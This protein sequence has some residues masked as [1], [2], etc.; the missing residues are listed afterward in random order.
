[1]KTSGAEGLLTS[2]WQFFHRYAGAGSDSPASELF[3]PIVRFSHFRAQP[4]SVLPNSSQYR[5][6]RE[7]LKS[8]CAIPFGLD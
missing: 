5:Y 6:Q 7:N 1:M 2:Y 3:S 8:K 4:I